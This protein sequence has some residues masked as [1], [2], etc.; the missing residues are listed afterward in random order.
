MQFVCLFIQIVKDLQKILQYF[1]EKNLQSTYR[2][3]FL[4]FKPLLL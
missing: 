2:G 4:Q 3:N 1:I